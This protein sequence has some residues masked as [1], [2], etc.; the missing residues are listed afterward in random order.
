[1]NYILPP[2]NT[3]GTFKLDEPLTNIINEKIIYS[4]TE[5]RTIKSLLKEHIDVKKLIY[6]DQGLSEDDYINDLTNDIPITTLESEGGVLLYIPSRLFSYV[7]QVTGITYTNRVVIV[8]L[9]YLPSELNLDYLNVEIEDLIKSK[10]GG[11]ASSKVETI[12]GTLVVNYEEYD[13][14]EAKRIGNINNR[15]T[16]RTLLKEAQ[17]SLAE[18]KFKISSIVARLK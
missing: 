13:V 17:D 7:P 14:A 18:Y 5:V 12:S 16:C 9:G 15:K 10:T 6:V 1:M 8:N 3:K 11:D 2:I 4:V